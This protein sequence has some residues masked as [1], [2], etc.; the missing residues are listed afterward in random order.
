MFLD[1]DHHTGKIWT[2]DGNSNGYNKDPSVYTTSRKAG[3]EVT[4][5][6]RDPEVVLYWGKI[7][8]SPLN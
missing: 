2:L 3:N 5:R 7:G 4:L 1:Y 8:R 6:L